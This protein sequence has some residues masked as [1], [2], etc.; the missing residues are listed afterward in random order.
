[1]KIT[2]LSSIILILSLLCRCTDTHKSEKLFSRCEKELSSGN[3]KNV[4]LI[5]DSLKKLNPFD[6]RMVYKADSLIQTAERISID[7]SLNEDQVSARLR[8]ILGEYSD[9]DKT[10]WEKMGWLEYRQIDG[11]KKYFNRAAN[12]LALIKSFHLQRA[13]KDSLISRQPAILFRKKHTESIIRES[14]DQ[15]APVVPAE[16]TIYYTI[17]VKPDV[18]PAGETVKCWLPYPKENHSRQA[19]VFLSAVSN[20][21]FYLAPDTAIHRNIYMESKAEKGLPVI[22][23]IIYTYKSSGQYFDPTKIAALPY[24]YNS[25]LYKKYTSEQVPNICF[26]EN[27]RHLADSITGSEKDPVEIVR[28]IYYWF[29]SNVPWAGAPEYS[30]IPNIPEYVLK[31]RRGDCG[32]QTFLLMSMLRYKGIPV[33]WQSGWMVPPDEKIPQ[34]KNDVYSA[35]MVPPNNKNLHDWCEVY[36]EGTGWVPVDISYGLQYSNNLKTRE[37]YISGIDSYRLIINDGIAGDLYPS[38]KFL[39]SEPFDFQRGEVEWR[40][41]N[42]YFDKWDYEMKIEYKK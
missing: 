26:T 6:S 4:V 36:Y 15:T 23:S 24:D 21:D 41:G 40:G 2:G 12:N 28:K 25:A 42:L 39:R 7:F 37:F 32:M 5:V 20:E 33:R 3:L 19:E 1:M 35:S 11:S 14:Q 34:N 31:N 8:R 22:F 16:M 10:M 17:T 9:E 27:I 30:I 13:L 38:K 18:V 29:D